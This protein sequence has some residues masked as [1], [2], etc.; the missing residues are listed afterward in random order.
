VSLAAVVAF[1]G[2]VEGSLDELR[3]LVGAR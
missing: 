3:A 1:S 2:M